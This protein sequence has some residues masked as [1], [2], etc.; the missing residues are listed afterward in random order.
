MFETEQKIIEKKIQ[1][2]YRDNSLP[3]LDEFK[4]VP[5]PFRGEWGISTSFFQ[6]AALEARQRANIEQEL[7]PV[8]QRAQEIAAG[9][10]D[11]LGTPAGFSRV[12]AIKGYINLYFSTEVYSARV[13]DLV[14]ERGQS[15]GCSAPND[16]LVMVEFSQP[17]TH[18]AFHVAHLRSMIYGDVLCRLMEC[19][20]YSVVRAN[21]YGDIGLH[22]IKWLW[23]Y[24][25]YHAGER[26]TED[27]TRW[28]GDMYAEAS[29]RLEENPELESEVRDI[30]AAIRRW[31]P[32]GK[33]QGSGRWMVSRVCMT[34]SIYTSTGFIP[35]ARQ[36]NLASFLSM[37]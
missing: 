10:A 28:M 8:P 34:Y 7:P 17:N 31:S 1:D 15:F 25:K 11:Y 20:G 14:L 6:T 29:R 23:N 9:L 30:Y 22:V 2:Y 36:K 33:K 26:P 12:E 5:V 18:K 32:C 4:W 19:A 27:T 37:S 3:E 16:K 21:Y 24:I 13:I 35:T